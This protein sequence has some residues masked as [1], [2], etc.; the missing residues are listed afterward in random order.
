MVAKTV[1]L[2][3]GFYILIF[4]AAF[5]KNSTGYRS[6]FINLTPSATATTATSVPADANIDTRLQKVRFAKISETTNM[7]FYLM[8]TAGS[9]LSV[10]Y[11]VEIVKI[12]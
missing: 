9:E 5:P 2:E 10:E 11:T 7:N 1:S 6:I 12:A 3:E 8:H 4:N